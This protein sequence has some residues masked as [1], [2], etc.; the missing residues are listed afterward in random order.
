MRVVGL[1]LALTC[2]GAMASVVPAVAA[3]KVHTA[4]VLHAGDDRRAAEEG[5]NNGTLAPV[6]RIKRAARNLAGLHRQ[7]DQRFAMQEHRALAPVVE[8]LEKA[9]KNLPEGSEWK[10]A[11]A[12]I[13]HQMESARPPLAPVTAPAPVPTTLVP[14]EAYPPVA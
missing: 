6:R 7:M 2:C 12:R 1:L 13:A 3:E 14:R 10:W 8:A 4:T 11:C 5:S 9:V